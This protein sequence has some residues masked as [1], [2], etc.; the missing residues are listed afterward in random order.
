[1]TTEEETILGRFRW[2]RNEAILHSD[3]RVSGYLIRLERLISSSAAYAK[4]KVG[5]ELLELSDQFRSRLAGETKG[6][7]SGVVVRMDFLGC[8]HHS[9]IVRH[10]T[11]KCFRTIPLF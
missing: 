11:C 5:V 7:R 2:T 10:R 4:E 6:N 8:K 3:A 9:D 1:M